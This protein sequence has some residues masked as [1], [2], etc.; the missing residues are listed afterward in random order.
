VAR[1][2][3][4]TG[5]GFG[6][7]GKGLF[8][9][10]LCRIFDAHTVVRFN[11]GAQAGH[12][13]VLPDG[14]HHTFSQFGAGSFSPGIHTILAE[15]V[16]V[17]PTALLE[18]ARHLVQVGIPDPLG[19]ILIDGD[20]RVTTPFHQA[21]NRVR[22]AQRPEPHG[23]CG[24]GIGE[25]VRFALANPDQALHYRDLFDRN[26]ALEKLEA[27]RTSLLGELEPGF[28][29]ADPLAAA[30]LSVLRDPRIGGLWMSMLAELQHRARPTS[31]EQ[32]AARLRR[33]GVVLFEGAQGVLLDQN[34]GF[35][36]HTT[37]SSV[38]PQSAQA[39]AVE[40]GS[41]EKIFNLGVM[42]CYLTRHGH[43]P[44]PTHDTLLDD[45]DEPHNSHAGWQGAFRRGHPDEV[46][47]RYAVDAVPTLDGLL[48]SHLDFFD[49]H[50]SLKWCDSYRRPAV[51]AQSDKT[52]HA[53]GDADLIRTL[54]LGKNEI[55]NQSRLTSL[56]YA[57][58]PE[59]SPEPV[60]SAEVVISRIETATRRRVFYGSF[61][62][63]HTD[64]RQRLKLPHSG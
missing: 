8:T 4:L 35:H 52:E 1:L 12:N 19:R 16:I 32:V 58:T 24:V 3:S 13:V 63:C 61:G 41:G 55:E 21:A 49:G 10:A 39:L 56:L 43:G 29:S 11:G 40:L 28:D 51:L 38:I 33:D 53:V 47:L 17:H 20:C 60:D 2:I 37:W 23:T 59:Y 44:F 14:R 46:L 25:T 6:D 57:V 48:V 22:E 15:P 34:A 50:R 18:E 7:C 45:L 9:D 26:C 31:K 5:L 42:R 30:E 54:I 64:V 36:P 62:P 27:V